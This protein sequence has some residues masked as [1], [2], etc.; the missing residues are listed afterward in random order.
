LAIDKSGNIF[1]S[2]ND[3]DDV[4]EIDYDNGAYAFSTNLGS[5]QQPWGVAVDAND[6]FYVVENGANDVI[7]ETASANGYTASVLPASGLS[8]PFGVAVDSAGD[9]YISD[10]GNNRI[11]RLTPQG[12]TYTQST[13]PTSALGLPMGIAVD[14]AGNVYICDIGHGRVIK[15]TPSGQSYTESTIAQNLPYEPVGVAI[16]G[17]GNVYILCFILG[18]SETYSVFKETP[19]AG[20]YVQSAVGFSPYQNPYGIAADASGN[21]FI[22]SPSS[23]G[24]V[25]LSPAPADFGEVNV[26]GSGASFTMIF[27]FDSGATLGTPQVGT[28]GVPALDFTDA[29]SGS[30]T[31]HGGGNAFNAGDSCSIDINFRPQFPG[32]RKGAAT[33]LD[34]AGNP[35]GTA[36]VTG[37]GVAPQAAFPPGRQIA[38]DTGLGHPEGVAVDTVGNIFVADNQNGVVY[39]ETR[40]GNGST[41]T[42]IG[43]GLNRPTA[44]AIDGAGNVFVAT[45]SGLY[46]ETLLDGSYTQ[47]ALITNLSDLTG[48]AVDGDGNLYLS[49]PTSGNVHKETLAIGGSY[50]ESAVGY[51][52]SHPGGLAVDASGSIFVTDPQQGNVYRETPAA[53]GSYLQTTV[54]SGVAG[55]QNVA[56]DGGGD[57]YITNSTNGE[58]YEETPDSSG[59]YVQSIAAATLNQAWGIGL[60]SQGDLYVSQGQIGGGLTEVDMSD[61]PVLN[62]AKTPVGSTSPAQLVTLANIGNAALDIPVL[63]SGDNPNIT[64]GFTLGASSTCPVLGTSG[65]DGSLGANSTCGYEISYT[66]VASGPVRGAM[67]IADY[68]LNAFTS[69]RIELRQGVTSDATRVSLRVTPDQIKAGLG[70]TL[71]ATVADTSVASIVPT[72]GSVTFTDTLLGNEVV[73][74]GGQPVPLGG[75]KAVLQILPKTGDHT[76]TAHYSGVNAAFA[77]ST[78]QALLTVFKN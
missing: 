64:P 24:L 39:K 27:T 21:V 14:S 43:S 44:V 52:I 16:D 31:Y 35:L 23:S 65:V 4:S 53:N 75:G 66:P 11:V 36:Y 20:G 71:T 10:G 37:T 38:F 48:V 18:G 77:G 8:G 54:A 15:E 51:G 17:S 60:D 47:K 62:F 45:A 12:N 6:N 25:E 19:T 9:I 59:G 28:Q 74:N 70:V 72:G 5:F 29:G 69:Q 26:A 67:V 50:T 42:V 22:D 7:K 13:V 76:I 46:Q 58:V 49:T 61:P 78:G 30:C 55:P 63:S 1:V 3:Y 73:L 40:S 41:R 56:V 57:V 2:D 33:L 34:T 68:S 32:L